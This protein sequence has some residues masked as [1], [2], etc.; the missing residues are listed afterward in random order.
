MGTDSVFQK[1][2]PFS[3]VYEELAEGISFSIRS[4]PLFAS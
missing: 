2:V 1:H 3:T 4:I